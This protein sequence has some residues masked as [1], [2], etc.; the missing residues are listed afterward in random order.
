MATRN[1]TMNM[2]AR[3]TSRSTAAISSPELLMSKAAFSVMDWVG[4]A[5]LAK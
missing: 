4:V 5:E 1:S 2:P 3:A